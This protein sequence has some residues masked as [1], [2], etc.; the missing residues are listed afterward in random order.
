MRWLFLVIHLTGFR[1]TNGGRF[2]RTS[3]RVCPERFNV[4]GKAHPDCESGVVV[5]SKP[6]EDR[7]SSLPAS[8]LWVRVT[9][10]YAPAATASLPPY[11]I[12]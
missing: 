6:A 7:H 8:C 1:M 5:K 4:G 9:A 12:S 11:T 2:L 10:A 3:A